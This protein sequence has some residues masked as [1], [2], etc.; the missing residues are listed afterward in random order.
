MTRIDSHAHERW[1][2]ECELFSLGFTQLQV[3]K[4]IGWSEGSIVKDIATRGG[5][6]AL[7]PNRPT[8][9]KDVYPVA[10]L[11]YAKRRQNDDGSSDALFE[12]VVRISELTSYTLGLVAGFMRLATRQF[13]GVPEG[14]VRLFREVF[15]IRDVEETA[16]GFS[17]DVLAIYFARVAAGTVPAPSTFEDAC[18]EIAN[19]WFQEIHLGE[20]VMRTD[21]NL[22]EVI[23]HCFTRDETMREEDIVS[24]RERFMLTHRFGLDGTPP[25]SLSEV[26]VRM[27]VS[28]T[29]VGQM[30]LEALNKL[31]RRRELF[32]P[33]LETSGD[34]LAE[35]DELRKKSDEFDRLHARL[36]AAEHLLLGTSAIDERVSEYFGNPDA[37]I[38]EP[39][40]LSKRLDEL[41][42]SVRSMHCFDSADIEFVGQL[43]QW[44]E[45]QLLQRKNFGRK[46]LIEVN[47]ILGELGLRLG[48][49]L[50]PVLAKRYRGPS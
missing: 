42:F 13:A 40:H 26:G 47:E 11:A 15:K 2:L 43:V 18:N 31:R 29:R 10:L 45:V 35:R 6:N 9:S 36:A 37:P 50:H 30:S 21:A 23:D 3:A 33:F 7:F 5:V 24:D 14:Y 48:M 27:G 17:G 39:A 16:K 19:V 20:V 28:K 34:V 4:A 1:P 44:S 25:E 49:R 41:G 12:P 22:V 8:K 46:S 38:V 32:R